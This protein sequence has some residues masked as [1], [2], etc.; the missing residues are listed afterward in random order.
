MTDC[1]FAEE[2]NDVVLQLFRDFN[3]STYGIEEWK[4]LTPIEFGILSWH[5]GNFYC[6]PLVLPALQPL[7]RRSGC[8]GRSPNRATRVGLT[9]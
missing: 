7:E 2:V 5:L 6:C 8:Q 3:D 4:T 1:L 9:N